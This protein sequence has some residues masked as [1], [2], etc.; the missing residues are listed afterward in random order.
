LDNHNTMT[1]SAFIRHTVSAELNQ[2]QNMAIVKIK[3]NIRIY[4][5]KCTK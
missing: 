1:F 4:F 3:D 5:S 2:G